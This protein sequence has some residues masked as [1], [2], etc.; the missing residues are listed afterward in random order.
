MFESKTGFGF[1]KVFICY[2]SEDKLRVDAL[3]AQLIE[4]G[5]GAAWFDEE[6]LLPGQDW[7]HEIKEALNSSH[8]ILICLSQ[9]SIKKTGYVQ[10]EIKVAL[11]GADKHPAPVII[12]AKLEECDIPLQ[13]TRWQWIN[14][15]PVSG[16]FADHRGYKKLMKMIRK[17]A[18]DLGTPLF[19][20]EDKEL[21]VDFFSLFDRPAFRGPFLWQTDP[22]PAERVVNLTL[23]AIKTGV[24]QDNQGT[25]WKRIRPIAQI[26]DKVLRSEMN[27]VAVKLKTASNLIALLIEQ[28]RAINANAPEQQGEYHTKRTNML[29]EIDIQRDLMIN[30]VNRIL[31]RFELDQLPVPTEAKDST[32][33]YEQFFAPLISIHR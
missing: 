23:K 24:V 16:A 31:E 22:G 11:K 33:V 19:Y 4:D 15:F 9:G 5:L 13:L 6:R 10:E 18:K 25:E 12:P 3:Y 29:L 27:I 28:D 14:I 20:K 2:A 32:N 26:R 7:D 8:V 1:L 30:M 21:F 17:I